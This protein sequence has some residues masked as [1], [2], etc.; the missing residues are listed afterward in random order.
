MSKI[1]LVEQNRVN[2]F[3]RLVHKDEPFDCL[4]GKCGSYT[5]D[6]LT[7]EIVK[8]PGYPRND[9]RN[10]GIGCAR[11]RMSIRGEGLAIQFVFSLGGPDE[12]LPETTERLLA[13]GQVFSSPMGWDLGWH[14]AF[15]P[16]KPDVTMNDSGEEVVSSWTYQ[17]DDCHLLPGITCH[18]DGSTLNADPYLEAFIN[19]GP[20]K[21]WEML[22]EYFKETMEWMQSALKAK[23]I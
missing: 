8:C 15:D 2:G 14:S 17:S 13:N 4:I 19:E 22:E 1:T 3:E 18:Y 23:E 10:H 6:P 21:V 20:D 16:Y 12:Y 5:I 11:Y 9:G 7:K